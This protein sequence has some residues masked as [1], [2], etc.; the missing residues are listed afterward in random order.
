MPTKQ[1]LLNGRR[2]NGLA[3]RAQTGTI[4]LGAGTSATATINAVDLNNA[5]IFYSG[6]RFAN[7]ASVSYPANAAQAEIDIVLTN[8]T[9]VTAKVGAALSGGWVPEFTVVEFWPGVFRSI[10]RGESTV[11]GNVD[12]VTV[13]LARPVN[14]N[15]AWV[16]SLGMTSQQASTEEIRRTIVQA[17]LTN[18]NTLTLRRGFNSDGLAAAYSSNISWQLVEPF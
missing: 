18:P 12:T 13:T 8:A 2:V 14:I 5:L 16:Q 17:E 6:R 4:S 9:T 11:T 3:M 7:T 15:R 1:W 10:Q